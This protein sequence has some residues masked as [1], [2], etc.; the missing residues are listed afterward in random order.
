M[1]LNKVT[2]PDI[3]H[4][5]HGTP[6]AELTAYD[7]P[8][9]KL[10]DEAGIDIV[11]VGDSL[12]MVVLGYPDTVSVTMEEMI[13]H[14]RAVVRGVQRALVVT[15]MPFGSYN[16]SIP[17]AISNATRIL[18]EGGAD[19]VKVEGGVEM[20][21]TVAAIVRAGIP[22]QGHIG[23]TPQTATS[24]GG[25]KVQ[26]KSAQAAGKLIAD[27]RALEEAGCFS[28]VLEAIPAPLAEHITQEITIPTIGIGAGP[29]C[30]G[31]VLVIH[32]AVGLYDRFTPKF[33]KQYARLNEP[34]AKALAQYKKDVESRAFPA[35][36]HS[37]T[38]KPEEMDKLLQ[39]Y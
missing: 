18:K 2:I 26:G 13:H 8:W 15:D 7:Y 34:V 1:H 36:E 22:V 39:L 10:V 31:Q 12:G 27:A 21:E 38:M 9:A 14:T 4:R 23:L 5:K 17:E 25:F 20:A 24:L 29:G 30:D 11:L 35:A 32:D 28:V 37:F 33:V 6:I 3:K 16:S 19:A